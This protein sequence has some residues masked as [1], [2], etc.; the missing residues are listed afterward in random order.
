MKP[1]GLFV[2]LTVLVY[3]AIGLA[4][5]VD[6]PDPNL[7]RVLRL[8]LQI[9]VGEEISEDALARLVSLNASDK[10]ITDLNGLG[11]CTHLTVLDLSSNQLTD[12]NGL[13]NAN[14]PNLKVV[15]LYNNQLKNLSGLANI[16]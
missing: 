9:N 6:I 8:A 16:D 3:Q 10:R 4:E 15:Y 13:V 5:R 14:L 7:R 11:H 1:I 12:L 2:L